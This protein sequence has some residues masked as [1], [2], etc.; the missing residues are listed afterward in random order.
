VKAK[1]PQKPSEPGKYECMWCDTE[2]AF[3]AKDESKV[4]CPNCGNGNRQ[5]LIPIYMVENPAEQ[6]LYTS[7]DFLPG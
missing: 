7:A 2:F 1:M 3:T 6:K 5:D 4:R